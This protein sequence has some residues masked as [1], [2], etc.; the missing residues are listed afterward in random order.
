L[1]DDND[2]DDNDGRP[3]SQTDLMDHAETMTG[4]V[5]ATDDA[6][7]LGKTSSETINPDLIVACARRTIVPPTADRVKAVDASGALG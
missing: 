7:A 4:H 3:F 1:S 5:P 6:G 2:D